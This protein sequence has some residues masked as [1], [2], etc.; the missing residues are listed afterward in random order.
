M[1]VYLPSME[2]ESASAGRDGDS[3]D[4]RV[5]AEPE[6][7]TGGSR[8]ESSAGAARHSS[9]FFSL[10]PMRTA[11]RPVTSAEALWMSV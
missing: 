8:V 5:V 10:P 9:I 11:R 6:G 2:W 4:A 1:Y 3:A 7:G